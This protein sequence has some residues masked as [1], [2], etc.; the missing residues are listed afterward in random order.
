MSVKQRNLDSDWRLVGVFA[1]GVAYLA[2][3]NKSAAEEGDTYYNTTSNQLMT[4]DGSSWSPAGMSGTSPGT[5]DAVANAGQK[6]TIDGALTTGI[7]IEAEDAKISTDGALLLLDN[8]DTGSD[9][10]CLELTNAGT[11]A[12]LQF[13]A[14]Q[15]GSDV[16][17]T[18]NLWILNSAGG[19]T[20]SSVTLGDSEPINFGGSTDAILQ[21]DTA[22]L[23][24][25]A[26][27]DSVL[28]IGAAA[29]S[30][31]VEFI[32]Q[33]AVTNLMKWDMDGGAD[34]LGGLVLDNVDLDIYDSDVIRFGDDQDVTM[35]YLDTNDNFQ[36]LHTGGRVSFGTDGD[37][38]DIYFYSD[39]AGNYMFWDEDNYTLEVY[40]CLIDL[41]D[42]AILRFGTSADIAFEYDGDSDELR[43]TG[44]G[45][46]IILGASGAG[47]DLKWW[48]N[49]AGDYILFDEDNARVEMVDID[50]A[51]ND[52]A[53]LYFGTDRDA[54]LKWDNDNSELDIVGNLNVSGT[55]TISGAFDIGHFAFGD[56]EEL[57]FGTSNDFV[58]QYDSATTNMAIDAATANDG[59][60]IGST[61]N[62]DVYFHGGTATYDVHFDA[63]AN[64]LG[65]LDNAELGFGNT[66]NAPD[67]TVAWDA[68]TL[69]ITGT[70]LEIRF[71]SS[72]EGMKVT[73]Y[74]ETVGADM[75][76]AEANDVLAIG[77]GADINLADNCS[78]LLGAGTT[79]GGD[80]NIYS[81]GTS[82]F[83]KEV[84]SAGKG[85]EFGID[86]KGVDVKFFGEL[87]T[88]FMEWDQDGNTDGA[89]V[90]D[91]A[92]AWFGDGDIIILGDGKD[93]S[94]SASGTTVTTTLAAGSAW[95][96]SDTDNAAS[97]IT[98]GTAGTNGLDLV[99]QSIT[100]GD[101]I[102]FDAA[103]KTLTFTDCSQVFDYDNGTVSYTLQADSND[104]L[105]LSNDDAAA[106]RL[107]LG[108]HTQTNG[109]D[110]YINSVTNGDD[111][112]FDA[113]LK[114]LTFDN[115]DI[116]LSD[117][118]ELRFGDAKDVL[119]VWD[120]TTLKFTAATND[121][122]LTWGG[123]SYGF[124]MTYYFETAGSIAIDY[125]GDDITLS[126][127]VTL[128]FG[129]GQDVGLRF[130][131]SNLTLSSITADEGFNIGGTTYGFDTTYY[132]ET[133]GTIDLDY[134]GKDMTF[135]DNVGLHLGTGDDITLTWDAT[136][137]VVDGNAANTV[138]AI[139]LTNN[140]DI[141]IY[142]D[143]TNYDVEFD[144]SAET[145]TFTDFNITMTGTTSAN[146]TCALQS[147]YGGLIIP[148]AATV[149][150]TTNES[151]TAGA[152]VYEVDASK[153][154]VHSAAGAWL[155]TVL[156]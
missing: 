26:A 51:F 42:D 61:V 53:Y 65:F 100:A 22:R 115:I 93:L 153:L 35:G 59:I 150:P 50:M 7:E 89:L 122:P 24:L 4:Y 38:P 12:A 13:T 31:D 125:D 17:G 111:I 54:S 126:D 109:M 44:S 127:E 118:D 143:D 116:A 137:L 90:F 139:G 23:A 55:L 62:T 66:A 64:T 32:G 15:A 85:V 18:G 71:G 94:M 103:N 46:T 87:S 92:D 102:T 52:D 5:L 142:G 78:L 34:S 141:V 101:H 48:G 148:I 86:G 108:T 155:G 114:T 151:P 67:V 2:D 152:I 40:D 3:C 136:K 33:T 91:N 63:S 41:D 99:F 56:D 37:A 130:D 49:A 30:Y 70:G 84:A 76:W 113:A 20:F 14:A 105:A 82:L 43:V 104:Y 19:G 156:S 133:S 134:D 120:Q 74:G 77:T 83:I 8:N 131:A 58:F 60:D 25:T 147:D 69:N 121:T 95:N 80:W 36:I 154:W 68:T 123:T 110:I 57:R 140:Q 106:A 11:A 29:F 16:Q 135:S 6:I 124:D 45:K 96:I 97:K 132:F 128:Q 73:F 81:D 117:D 107:V 88:G 149:A 75:V 144:T 146:I 28:R 145:V 9:V 138:I 129:T 21:W 27:A 98:F 79:Y 39:T 1:T 10:H 72:G 119:M 112:I 47:L